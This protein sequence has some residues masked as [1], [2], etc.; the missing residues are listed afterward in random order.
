MKPKFAV[1]A[2]MCLAIGACNRQQDASDRRETARVW[3]KQ[4]EQEDPSN[5]NLAEERLVPLGRDAVPE[6]IAF[7]EKMPDDEARGKFPCIYQREAAYRMLEKIGPD[8]VEAIPFLVKT[9]QTKKMGRV[10]TGLLD[11]SYRKAD[12]NIGE[13][14]WA[15]RVLG[16]IGPPAKAAIDPLA[17]AVKD[18]PSGVWP[19]S[20]FQKTALEA[21]KKIGG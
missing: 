5:W 8:A 6:L 1:M 9:L 3:I 20:E 19:E 16:A 11:G 17:D 15:A 7:L 18:N 10:P 13:Q 21:I 12:L 14:T 4:L 2:L